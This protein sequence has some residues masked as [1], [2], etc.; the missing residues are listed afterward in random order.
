METQQPQVPQQPAFDAALAAEMERRTI[1]A[2][3]MRAMKNGA[4]NFYWIAAL[5]VVNSVVNIF[6]GGIFFVMGLGITLFIDVIAGGVAQ[7]F[8]G[9]PIIIVMGLLFSLVFDAIFVAFGYF[10]GKG[11]RWAFI[12]GMVLYGLD[13][14]LMLVSQDWLAFGF[15]LFFLYGVWQGFSA[16]GKL[17]AFEAANP[18]AVPTAEMMK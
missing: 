11:Y 1:Q 3:L 17:R 16:L 8:G 12:A 2:N 9:S 10:A 5:S 7:E 15:H 14:V 13:A 18:M 6:G 4:S